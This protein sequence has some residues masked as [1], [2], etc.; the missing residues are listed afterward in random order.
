MQQKTVQLGNYQYLIEHI[1]GHEG[2]KISQPFIMIRKFKAINEVIIDT[3][4]FFIEKSIYENLQNELNGKDDIT[5][6][7]IESVVFP[8][9]ES[10]LSS[11]SKRCTDFNINLTIDSFDL[12]SGDI[13]QLLDNEGKEI[14]V[15]CDT[16]KVYHPVTKVNQQMIVCI[17]N[18]IN[19]IH[20]YYICNKLE[21]YKSYS[22]T[23]Q[24]INNQLYSEYFTINFP[25]FY[26]LFKFNDRTGKAT[27]YYKENI[28]PIISTKNDEFI[29]KIYAH[30]EV[31]R[32]DK[33]G[34]QL[35]PL[36]LLIQPF[37]IVEETIEFEGEKM[38]HNVKLYLKQR[39]SIENNY[40]SF[41]INVTL[42][43]F[44]ENNN[45]LYSLYEEMISNS[46]SFISQYNFRIS[47]TLGF[48]NGNIAILSN[49]LYPNTVEFEDI[50]NENGTMLKSKVLQAYEYFYNVEAEEYN[51]FDATEL[52]E[53]KRIDELTVSDL[54]EYDK[55]VAIYALTANK[56]L[57]D[58]Q[59]YNAMPDKYIHFKFDNIINYDVFWGDLRRKGLK[60]SPKNLEKIHNDECKIHY[61]SV[62]ESERIDAALTQKHTIVKFGSEKEFR[63][64]IS[65]LDYLLTIFKTLKKI[66]IREE[67]EESLDSDIHFIGFKI[68][69]ASDKAF[70]QLVYKKYKNISIFDLDNF[71]F[72]INGLFDKWSELPETLVA[73]ISFIDRYL[74]N[75]I[76]SNFIV[77][78]KEWFKY[79]INDGNNGKLTQLEEA[80]QNMKEVILDK[81]H[82]NFI[83]NV[84]CIIKKEVDEDKTNIKRNTP[85][86]IYRPIFYKVADLQNIKIRRSV[87]QNIGVNLLNY[88]TKVEAFKMIIDG[89]EIVESMRNDAYVIFT[90]DAKNLVNQGGEY[91]IITQDDEYINTGNWSL[92]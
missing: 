74:N 19:G 13:Y 11:Y 35:I 50:F 79:I 48:N 3:D 81:D 10:K 34:E 87:K 58:E 15:M 89:K 30:T 70:K 8:V 47:S 64:E 33:E 16:L 51:D 73:R 53:I 25:N 66:G 6:Y 26:E 57:L 69:I 43:P 7:N 82:I 90:I 77:I 23:E 24:N 9:P 5:D 59:T 41:P 31:E 36:G 68:E 88:M 61:T 2:N 80:N 76:V 65:N 14:N 83:N 84:Q 20:F 62:I 17:E 75:I 49:F 1:D 27:V 45:D 60:I 22:N 67:Y 78:T 32:Y 86:I 42:F 46:I 18:Y 40:I 54:T 21:N 12:E 39:S 37:K 56:K 92:Y 28:V 38:D 63:Y 91:D 55:N 72:E 44:E 52:E 71:S 29:S 85:K 4:I